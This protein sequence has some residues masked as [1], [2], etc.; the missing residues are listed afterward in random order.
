MTTT[1]AYKSPALTRE[2]GGR[3]PMIVLAV[4]LAV[5]LVATVVLS[6][7]TE[8]LTHTTTKTLPLNG[9]TSLRV[10]AGSGDVRITPVAAGQPAQARA[11]LHYT[12]SAPDLV[13]SDGLVKD[14][15]G[16]RFGLFTRCSVDWQISVPADLPVT[17]HIGSGDLRLRGMTN[18]IEAEAGSGDVVIESSR[19]G[20]LLLK[21]GSGDITART[22][23]PGATLQATNGSG[24]ITADFS[25][26]PQRVTVQA[27]SGDVRVS[28]PENSYH[29]ITDTGSG[30]V[31]NAL[32][33]QTSD[34]VIQAK[35]GSGDI[36]LSYR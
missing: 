1:E 17:A 18:R 2:P 3:A 36:S 21:A 31:H 30:D 34:R 23:A 20:E 26:P 14:G 19:S 28:V 10:E 6:L 16:F 7:L 9:F 35:V 11:T 25:Q 12:G 15:C 8:G 24:D 13:V 32:G 33:D 27:G 5:A 22:D 29:T 4:L